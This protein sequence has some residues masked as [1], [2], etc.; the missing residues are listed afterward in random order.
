MH[1]FI[2]ARRWNSVEPESEQ[3]AA[4]QGQE[5]DADAGESGDKSG[6]D[7]GGHDDDN[8]KIEQRHSDRPVSSR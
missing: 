6:D 5:S 3:N 2:Y 8:Q 4:D 1:V 7:R